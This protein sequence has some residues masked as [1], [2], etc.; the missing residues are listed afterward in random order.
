MNQG[1]LEFLERQA[2]RGLGLLPDRAGDV[3]RKQRD[4]QRRQALGR[5][6]GDWIANVLGPWDWFMNPIT[7]R[8]RQPDFECHPAT[9]K[10]RTYRS[11]GHAGPVRLFKEDPQL[12]DWRPDFRGRRDPGPPVS[13][14]ALAEIKEFLF[15]IQEPAGHPIRAMIAEEFGRVGGRYHAHVLVAGVAHLRRDE[16]WEKAY[17]RFGRTRISPF[18]RALGGAFYAAKYASKQLG[19]LHFI[20]PAPGAE[21]AAVMSPGRA[22]GGVDILPSP[23][24]ERDEIR[25]TEFFPRGW[26]GWRAKR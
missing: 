10:L 17:A 24:M 20:G 21:F 15:R 23:E 14:K 13:Y 22:V 4:Y 5:I 7:F 8:H 11:A 16:W 19:E 1:Y 9:G 25:R 18:D 6:L 2:H 3:E 12:K 26:S